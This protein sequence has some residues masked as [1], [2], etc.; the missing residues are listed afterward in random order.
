MEVDAPAQPSGKPPAKTHAQAT[1]GREAQKTAPFGRTRQAPNL[2]FRTARTSNDK[3]QRKTVKWTEHIKKI[4]NFCV[5]V[6]P[7][8]KH[9]ITTRS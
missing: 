3:G 7:F 4:S 9:V 8:I 1:D 6:H 5:P 2:R